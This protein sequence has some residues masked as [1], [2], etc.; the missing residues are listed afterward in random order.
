MMRHPANMNMKCFALYVLCA[1]KKKKRNTERKTE[2]KRNDYR[3]VMGEYTLRIKTTS[4]KNIITKPNSEMDRNICLCINTFSIDYFSTQRFFFFSS[5]F[6]LPS[7]TKKTIHFSANM[8]RLVFVC[9]FSTRW[10]NKKK[11]LS[12]VNREKTDSHKSKKKKRQK[13]WIIEYSRKL[14]FKLWMHFK[15]DNEFFFLSCFSIYISCAHFHKHLL[16]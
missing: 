9:C 12:Q 11:S 5:I 1:L 2:R 14:A 13:L 4:M 8:Q 10:A 3:N 6:F 15:L 7:Y 16:V